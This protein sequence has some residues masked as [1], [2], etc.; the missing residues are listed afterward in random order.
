MLACFQ[1]W[2]TISIVIANANLFSFYFNA[3]FGF[4]VGLEFFILFFMEY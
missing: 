3:F 4:V 2:L 1:N